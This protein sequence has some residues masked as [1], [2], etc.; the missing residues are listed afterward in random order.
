MKDFVFYK[1]FIDL[2]FLSFILSYFRVNF[3]PVIKFIFILGGVRA[4]SDDI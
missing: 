4:V 3:S 1:S 2:N